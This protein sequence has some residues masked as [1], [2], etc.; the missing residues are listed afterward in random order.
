[1]NRKSKSFVNE[2]STEKSDLKR[3]AK[4]RRETGEPWKVKTAPVKAERNSRSKMEH[5][6]N[7]VNSVSREKRDNRSVRSA[8]V[9]EWWLC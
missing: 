2:K 9:Q 4:V 3:V 6:V 1:M 5:S 7:S 8:G